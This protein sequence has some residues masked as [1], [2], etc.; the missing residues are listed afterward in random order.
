M[1]S[2]IKVIYIYIIWFFV[3][4]IESISEDNKTLPISCKSTIPPS[5]AVPAKQQPISNG[6]N[7]INYDDA[8][9]LTSR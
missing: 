4:S 1:K 2:L 8:I 6:K 5:V 3:V 7:T 9:S